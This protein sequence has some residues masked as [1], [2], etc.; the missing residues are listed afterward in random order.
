MSA[1]GTNLTTICFC[2][3][4]ENV[5]KDTIYES[6]TKMKESKHENRDSSNVNI[7]IERNVT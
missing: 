1:L 3:T 4:S 2:K 7:S 5:A 6:I